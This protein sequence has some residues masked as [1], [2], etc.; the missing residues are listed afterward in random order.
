MSLSAT[1]DGPLHDGFGAVCAGELI[2]SQAFFYG[3]W[4]AV[5]Y[6]I[7]ASLMLVTFWGALT[8]HYEKD[9][10]LNASQ[11]TLMLQTILFLMYL[12]LG[13]LV[14]SN[15]EPWNYL[16]AVYWANVTLFTVGFGDFSA[17]TTLGRALL[18]PYALIGVI[19]L[20]L[21]I[22][23]IRSM[24]LQRGH[25]RLD[26]RAEEKER[27]QVLRAMASR[28]GADAVLH[29]VHNDSCSSSSA[30]S[31]HA[32]EYDRRRAE[33]ELMRTIQHKALTRRRWRAMLVST[34]SWLV[35][36]LAGAAVFLDL[37][38]PYQDWTYF[39]AF[40]FCFVTLTTIGY[41]D[42]TPASNAGKSFFVFWSLLALPTMTVLISNAE[43][44]VVKFVRD[45]TL[46]IGNLT[47]LPGEGAF[48]DNLRHA[49]SRITC[50]L[51]FCDYY[52][53]PRPDKDAKDVSNFP[54][55][56]DAS[57][58]A[59]S[60]SPEQQHQRRHADADLERRGRPSYSSTYTSHV[61]RS[62]SRFRDPHA[63]LP[64]D[65]DLHFLLISEIQILSQHMREPVPRRYS[66]DEWAW[67]LR[68]LG[69]DERDPHR[70]RKPAAHHTH[71]RRTGARRRHPAHK[72]HH[73]HDEPHDDE[74]DDHRWS[75]VGHQSPLMGS[76]EE[77]EWIFERLT[78]RLRESLSAQGRR[79]KARDA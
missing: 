28:P 69:Q 41:G 67:Y 55:S 47:I 6:F 53:L 59:G 49:I 11:R 52:V 3:I 8:G 61:R 45:A 23:S 75:W 33:F 54:L 40:Y 60:V 44:T 22:A 72:Q 71:H 70:H 63:D 65:T 79:H 64:T 19:S 74:K 66:F 4:A 13:A 17:S 35:L 57:S 31:P 56:L 34:G 12:L 24:I 42:R 50:R 51:L 1:A 73:R 38:R 43:D 9:F 10:K 58:D 5:L 37:E 2:W 16:D 77:S 62:L 26:A 30:P 20:G 68:L 29:P 7:M 46:Q 36:W 48:A 18:F 32:T 78:N 39:D 76:Q 21:V 15:I 27:R 25:R 14:F